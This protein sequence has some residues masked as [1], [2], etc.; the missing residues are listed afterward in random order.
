M[1]F[2]WLVL[3]VRRVILG[4]CLGNLGLR[5]YFCAHSRWQS[6]AAIPTTTE[7]VITLK[8]AGAAPPLARTQP[9]EPALLA[10]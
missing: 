1:A 2:T 5:G 8:Q 4:T 6:R 7:A 3:A 9:L 10:R